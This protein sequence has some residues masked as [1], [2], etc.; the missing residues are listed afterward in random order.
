M[1]TFWRYLR[2]QAFVMLCGIVGPLFLIIYFVGGDPALSWMLWTG[3]AVTALDILIAVALTVAGS[4]HAERMAVLEH[5]GV[6]ALATV[7]AFG[8][9]NTRI[10]DRPLLQLELQ[11]SG[12]GLTLFTATDRVIG[13]MD[14]LPMITSRKLV[15]L[16]DPTT[17]RF[18]IDWPRSALVS[19]VVPATFELAED[20]RVYDLTGQTEPLL[21][22]LRILRTHGIGL[23]STLDL[24]ADPAARQQVQEVVRRAAGP[25]TAAPQPAG[26]AGGAAVLTPPQPSAAQRLQELETLRATGVSTEDEYQAKRREIIAEL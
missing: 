6:L 1:S 4:R 21:E 17:N 10:N 19:G 3:L 15:A 7:T 16:V 13:T 9:T 12:P 18:V 26:A 11:I 23:E 8:E 24:R 22:V 20:G 25:A 2:V 5:H 14:R